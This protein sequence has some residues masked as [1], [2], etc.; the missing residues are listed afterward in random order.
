MGILSDLAEWLED[1]GLVPQTNAWAL[2]NYLEHQ[3]YVT[4]RFSSCV[5]GPE[6]TNL[7]LAVDWTE[8]DGI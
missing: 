1:L 6:S 4:I 8:L 2:I 3:E 5:C 7:N